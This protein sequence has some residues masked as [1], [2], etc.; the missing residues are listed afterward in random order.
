MNDVNYQRRMN[1]PVMKNI[2]KDQI[3]PKTVELLV[4][5]TVSPFSK[6]FIILR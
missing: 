1:G 2:K 6:L 3:D 5:L 4:D